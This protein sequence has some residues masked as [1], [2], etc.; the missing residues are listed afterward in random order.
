MAKI[1]LFGDPR[2]S[3]IE[4]PTLNLAV[5]VQTEARKNEVVRDETI[6]VICDFVGGYAFG[7]CIGLGFR[8]VDGW[9]TATDIHTPRGMPSVSSS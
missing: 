5:E 7:D 2:A 1:R 8:S 3:G 6:D 4:Q 9:W